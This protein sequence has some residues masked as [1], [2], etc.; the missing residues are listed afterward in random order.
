MKELLSFEQAPPFH[1]PL[2]FL[3]SAIPF[4]VA[5]G[6]LLMASTDSLGSRWSPTVLALTHLITAGLML[7]AMCGA[8]LQITPVAIGANVPAPALLASFVHPCLLIGSV[9]LVAGFLGAGAPCFWLGAAALLAGIVPFAAVTLY[10]LWRA[11]VRNPSRLAMMLALTG[12]LAT[13]LYGASLA[14]ARGGLPSPAPLVDT[15]A[16]F[17]LGWM[18]WGLA[19]LCG[20]SYLV[21]PMFQLTPQFP[22]RFQRLFIPALALSAVLIVLAPGHWLV[23]L[24]LAAL[25]TVFATTTLLLQR[26]RRRPRVDSSFRFWQ[27]ALLSILAAVILS[28]AL[29]WLPEAPRAEVLLGLLIMIGGFDS[30]ICGMMYKIVPFLAWL[31]LNNAGARPLLMHQVIEE[32][33]MRQHLRLHAAALPP[34]MLSPW[35]P[36]FTVLAGGLL[37]AA[38]VRQ[39]I[40][41][42]KAIGR[43]HERRTEMMA[44]S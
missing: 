10:A 4:G 15:A 8:I 42:A 40:N 11:P 21:V 16:H 12:L 20:A 29:P 26:R 28:V 43:Y 13:A 9:S 14:L 36:A 27:L 30:V 17:R 2:R 33:L 24:G 35:V 38:H 22:A 6:L 1:V 23:D 19:L 5:A 25:A 7:Q 32:P 44:L 31:H 34:L 3:L 18:V 37:V 39:A 41:M